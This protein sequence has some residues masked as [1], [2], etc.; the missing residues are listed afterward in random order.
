MKSVI[1]R[2]STVPALA[3]TVC[4]AVLFSLKNEAQNLPESIPV[5]FGVSSVDPVVFDEMGLPIALTENDLVSYSFQTTLP[6]TNNIASVSIRLGTT[7]GGNDIYFSDENYSDYIESSTSLYRNGVLLKNSS[8]AVSYG[9]S[10]YYE[11]SLY[12]LSGT[13]SYKAI[14]TFND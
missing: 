5:I 9:S 7:V 11:L 8:P 14:G 6:D 10:L 1:R 3:I 12:D 4:F 13:C 2:I